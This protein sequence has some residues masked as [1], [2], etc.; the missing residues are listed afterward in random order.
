MRNVVLAMLVAAVAAG[1]GVL[2]YRRMAGDD[3]SAIAAIEL[4]RL[5]LPDRY[6]KVQD[7]QQWRTKILIVNFWATWCEPCREEVPDLL[8]IQAKHAAKSVQVVGIAIDSADKVREFA[9]EYHIGY[10][11]LI[12]G[13]QVMDIARRLGNA[14]GG[15]PYTVVMDASGQVVAKRLGRISEA[16]LEAA[17]RLASG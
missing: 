8:K 15:L 10:P 13:M 5:R 4:G 6:G 14:A 9:D 1:A 2:G 3:V 7:F 17:V 12:G 11:L 16:Q